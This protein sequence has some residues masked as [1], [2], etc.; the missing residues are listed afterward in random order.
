ML[1]ARHGGPPAGPNQFQQ[2]PQGPPQSGPGGPRQ[3]GILRQQLRGQ[4]PITNQNFQNQPGMQSNQ[5]PPM[6]YQQQ[7]M[8]QQPGS[9]TIDLLERLSIEF[10]FINHDNL[11]QE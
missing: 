4:A 8:P 2:F 11:L 7:P 10:C 6:M 1:R 9:V 3:Q 5:G